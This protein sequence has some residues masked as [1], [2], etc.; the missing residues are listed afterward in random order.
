MH[1][2]K[3]ENLI[4]VN[5]HVSHDKMIFKSREYVYSLLLSLYRDRRIIYVN[6]KNATLVR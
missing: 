4:S 6:A 2:K 5:S 3:K 1:L